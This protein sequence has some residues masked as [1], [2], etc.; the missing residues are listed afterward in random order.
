[1]RRMPWVVKSTSV[2]SR[3]STPGRARS[4]LIL[5]KSVTQGCHVPSDPV[6]EADPGGRDHRLRRH[7]PY[8]GVWTGRGPIELLVAF[9]EELEGVL[10]PP[11]PHVQAV[12][13]DPTVQ[14]TTAGPLSAE[15]PPALVDGD[16]LEVITP[17]RLAQPPRRRQPGHARHPGSRPWVAAH[18]L[19]WSPAML[20][21]GSPRGRRH[22]GRAVREPGRHRPSPSR[23]RDRRDRGRSAA[24]RVRHV[25]VRARSSAS[26]RPAHLPLGVEV[27]QCEVAQGLG[28]PEVHAGFTSQASESSRQRCALGFSPAPP[29]RAPV[30]IR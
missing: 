19:Q 16:G 30:A 24:Q 5:G 20:R 14:S 21:P 4:A 8:R 25:W 6:G 13:L 27:E 12:F 7:G 11:E 18:S 28:P 26:R 15:P 3:P 23:H 1:M 17:A 22:C 29:W 2:R 10:V 9:V